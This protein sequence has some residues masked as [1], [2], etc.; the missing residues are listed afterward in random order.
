MN[1]TETSILSE[2]GVTVTTHRAIFPSATYAV[3]NVTSVMLRQRPPNKSWP[4]LF[5]VIGSFIFIMGGW[6]L[7]EGMGTD[8]IL[9]LL[10]GG[11]IGTL[12]FLWLR[13]LKPTFLVYVGTAGA[14]Q[15]A[16]ES[17]DKA[18]AQRVHTALNDAIIQ[19]G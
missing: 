12:G 6:F 17:Y 4:Q 1:Q 18:A 2:G 5:L 11:F 15:Q 8:A 14:E 13:S 7:T 19:R 3:A 16:F 9:P 10:L